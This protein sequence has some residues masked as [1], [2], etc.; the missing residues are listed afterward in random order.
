MARSASTP[1]VYP[2]PYFQIHIPPLNSP[3]PV[4]CALI[5]KAGRVLI[6]QRP[7][8]KHLGGLW[9]FPGGKIEADE[10]PTE[11]L[12]RE[13]S[14]ELGCIV[15]ITTALDPVV[16]ADPRAT[17][18]LHPFIVRLATESLAPHA[19]E[20]IALRWL[21]PTELSKATLAPADVPVVESYLQQLP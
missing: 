2:N 13:I 4:C 14:E 21:K 9:E 18:E 3:I 8:D 1:Y 20:H 5:E 6:A 12:H 17:I 7:F 10:S 11:A 16:H 19:R 15:Q